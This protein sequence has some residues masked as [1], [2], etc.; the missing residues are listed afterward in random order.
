MG[1][2]KMEINLAKLFTGTPLFPPKEKLYYL[3][4]PY[5]HP[6]LFVQVMRYEII[7]YVAADLINDGYMLIEPI[8]SCAD[9]SNKYKLPGGYTYWQH[10]DRKLI[11]RCDGVIVVKMEGWEESTGV[12]DELAYAGELGLPVHTLELDSIITPEMWA[13]IKG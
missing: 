10:R 2:P 12:N 9:K 1:V 3:A 4:S 6:S 11:E 13:A 7:N 8:A 5:S